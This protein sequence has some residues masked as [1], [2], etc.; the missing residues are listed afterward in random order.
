ML[1]ALE[2]TL[3]Y[4]LLDHIL[5]AYIVAEIYFINISEITGK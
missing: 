4:V 5:P 3:I 2:G 1:I